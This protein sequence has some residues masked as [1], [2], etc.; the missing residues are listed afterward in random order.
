SSA[1]NRRPDEIGIILYK[2]KSEAERDTAAHRA[3]RLDEI[4]SASI[5]PKHRN[6]PLRKQI[7]HF[8]DNVHMPRQR[9]Y[10]RDRLTQ[11]QVQKWIALPTGGIDHIARRQPPPACPPIGRHPARL[12]FGGTAG[13]FS[14]D[15]VVVTHRAVLSRLCE[16]YIVLLKAQCAAVAVVEG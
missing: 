1:K 11:K 8:H 4:D 7:A 14:G 16:R 15:C 6:I 5:L 10:A 3:R 13:K 2:S 9:S 12:R